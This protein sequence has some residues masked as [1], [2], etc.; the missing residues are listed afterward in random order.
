MTYFKFK[1]LNPSCLDSGIL[2]FY[3]FHIHTRLNQIPA[4]D[5]GCC[6]LD[7]LVQTSFSLKCS[8]ML[9]HVCRF[10]EFLQILHYTWERRHY[11]KI[12]KEHQYY[13]LCMLSFLLSSLKIQNCQKIHS[14]SPVSLTLG[15]CE[16]LIS[17]FK[18]AQIKKYPDKRCIY[19]KHK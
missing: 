3:A 2:S 16:F 10:G 14:S 12:E 15:I 19:I 13:Y 18:K 5:I 7:L 1:I 8:L 6:W 11:F 9:S 17:E 4:T